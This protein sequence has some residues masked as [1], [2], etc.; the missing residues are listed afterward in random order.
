M[1]L[2]KST[3]S[4]EQILSAWWGP[5][6]DPNR[7]DRLKSLTHEKLGLPSDT[8]RCWSCGALQ[9]WWLDEEGN[10]DEERNTKIERCHIVAKSLRGNNDPLNLVLLCSRCHRHS[11]DTTEPKIMFE[12]MEK[13]YD[14]RQESL[15]QRIEEFKKWFPE[16]EDG[17]ETFYRVGAV[18]YVESSKKFHDL[19]MND[20]TI[21]F[22]VKYKWS[23][24]FGLLS[25][26]IK[27]NGGLDTFVKML[28]NITSRKNNFNEYIRI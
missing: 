3:P 25:K 17:K 7:K 24:H 1:G 19:L 10:I 8:D 5:L 20:S 21:H 6:N 2:R 18:F 4:K 11:P 22:G 13:E 12:W 14:N 15:R 9:D 27:D 23:T 16:I 28:K 26:Y